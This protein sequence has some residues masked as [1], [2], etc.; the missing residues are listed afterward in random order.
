MRNARL[1]CGTNTHAATTYQSSPHSTLSAALAFVEAIDGST[2]LVVDNSNV[3]RGGYDR[4][5]RIDFDAVQNFLGGDFLKS[6]AMSV[7][8]A[9][10]PNQIAFYEHLKRSGWHIH[11]F[12]LH[13]HSGELTENEM[14]VDGDVRKLIRAAA[15]ANDCQNV[16][17]MS[18][19]GGMTNAVK[20]AR[21]A[22]K[23]VFVIAWEGTLHPAL[24]A[25]ATNYM[26]IDELRPLIGRSLH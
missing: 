11:G 14:R 18:G 16:V 3:F 20:D 4:D 8:Q 15:N 2:S 1:D 9:A 25:A 6:A 17:V 19:D 21:R 12:G 10:R 5:F 24:A 7:S 13:A 26:T 22:G 23:R